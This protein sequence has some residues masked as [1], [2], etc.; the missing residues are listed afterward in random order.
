MT[1]IE[2]TDNIKCWQG[3]EGNRRSHMQLVGFEIMTRSL[4]NWNYP[5]WIYVCMCI[6]VH[7]YTHTHTCICMSYKSHTYMHVLQIINS[8]PMKICVHGH[9]E[10]CTK[11]FTLVSFMMTPRQKNRHIKLWYICSVECWAT[12]HTKHGWGSGTWSWVKRSQT[13]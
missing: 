11:M 13:Q 2:K 6:H 8:N 9:Q 1:K 3:L 4:G 10:T 7:A 12:G 5:C